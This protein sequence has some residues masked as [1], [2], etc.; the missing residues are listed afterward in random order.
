MIPHYQI[1]LEM[2]EKEHKNGT[3]PAANRDGAEN[4]GGAK[5]GNLDHKKVAE[6]ASAISSGP[7]HA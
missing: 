1:A 7:P 5:E 4:H 6:R 3:D 2:A